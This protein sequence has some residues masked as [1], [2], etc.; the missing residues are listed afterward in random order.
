MP[1]KILITGDEG[2]LGRILQIRLG[3]CFNIIPTAKSPTK[4]A[5][6]NRNVRQMD[7]TNFSSV[8]ACI[9]AENP[10]VIINCAAMTNVD[11]CEKDHSAARK[12]NVE[13]VQ[14]IVKAVSK[15]IKIIQLSTDYVFEGKDGPYAESDPTHPI[16]YYGR[17]KLEGENILRGS[18]NPHCI[19]RGS[20]LYGDPIND[21]PNFF[22][23][24]YDSLSK[25]NTI[26][27]VTDQTSNPAWLPALSDAIMK[28]ILLNAEGVY[29]FGSD[30]HLSRYDFAVLIA[31]V[32]GFDTTLINPATSDSMPF[33][34]PRPTHSGLAIKKISDKLDVTTLSTINCLNMI[35]KQILVT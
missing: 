4:M 8:E 34:A 19:L 35:K 18:L 11:A 16:S 2:Q 5:V 15:R 6:K 12:V 3:K 33:I 26:N 14:N 9:S 32:F 7:I 1:S 17:S 28:V 25:N 10:D 23:W 27:V 30:D 13:G 21:K 31:N 24:A 20:V 29:H 22:A